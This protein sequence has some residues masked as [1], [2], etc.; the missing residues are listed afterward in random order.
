MPDHRQARLRDEIDKARKGDTAI[1]EIAYTQFSDKKV[2]V[3]SAGVLDIGKNKLQKALGRVERLRDN[4]AHANEYA[5]S[6]D[7][8]KMVCETVRNL[9]ELKVALMHFLEDTRRRSSND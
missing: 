4:L 7:D 1:S 3:I 9:Y 6:S 5:S 2:L 8:A